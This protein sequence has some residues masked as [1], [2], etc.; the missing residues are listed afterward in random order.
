MFQN[1]KALSAQRI[2][3]PPRSVMSASPRALTNTRHI[4]ANCSTD[5]I[6]SGSALRCIKPLMLTSEL[7]S[8]SEWLAGGAAVFRQRRIRL[9]L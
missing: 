1:G 8:G 9:P 7:P 2:A 6:T 5:S 3:R 4:D